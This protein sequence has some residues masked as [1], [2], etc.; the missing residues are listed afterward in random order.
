M[1]ACAGAIVLAAAEKKGSGGMTL[2]ELRK[3]GIQAAAHDHSWLCRNIT[4]QLSPG[5]YGLFGPN[6]CGKTA[7]L[8]CLAGIRAFNEGEVRLHA[9]GV[10]LKGIYYR[11]RLGYVPQQF[12]FYEEMK[13]AKFLRYV[14]RMK[15]LDGAVIDQRIKELLHFVELYSERERRIDKLSAGEKQRLAIA[16]SLLNS[17]DL[18]LL[19]EPFEN[20]DYE[21]KDNAMNTIRR[22]AR[23]SVVLIASHLVKE[24]EHHL[25]ASFIMAEGQLTGPYTIPQWKWA[26]AG[27]DGGQL[28]DPSDD[29]LEGIYLEQIRRMR[30]NKGGKMCAV[31]R[32]LL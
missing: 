5:I 31:T 29:N 15:L 21:A 12:A 3:A 20:L 16:Q 1:Y 7:L 17:P 25:D 9:G 19:D 2:L 8:E 22:F 6:G 13:V 10:L 26:I 24:I 14:A 4:I 11:E 28:P 23:R 27:G 30:M 18:L 32:D